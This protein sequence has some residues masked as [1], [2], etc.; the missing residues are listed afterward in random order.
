MNNSCN[1]PEGTPDGKSELRQSC[2]PTVYLKNVFSAFSLVC[3]YHDSLSV[4]ANPVHEPAEKLSEHH[5]TLKF[6]T[7]ISY[8]YTLHQIHRLFRTTQMDG[9]WS[10]VCVAGRGG[11]LMG[12]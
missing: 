4:N 1:K 8:N 10:D 7:V 3:D 11:W 2:R 5:F 6:S 9:F 12:K